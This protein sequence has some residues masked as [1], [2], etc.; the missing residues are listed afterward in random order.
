MRRDAGTYTRD[1]AELDAT[2]AKWSAA[3]GNALIAG[4]E[5]LPSVQADVLEGARQARTDSDSMEGRMKKFE[6]DAAE[7][8]RLAAVMVRHSAAGAAEAAGAAAR[9]EGG[10][11]AQRAAAAW[12]RAMAAAGRADAGG[13]RRAGP[14]RGAAAAAP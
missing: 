13:A 8:R 4:A 11:G 1:A 6:R 14:R 5:S 12:K 2:A 3:G 9:G 10:P 7:M